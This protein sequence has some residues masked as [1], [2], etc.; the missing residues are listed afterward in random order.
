MFSSS[1]VDDRC[2]VQPEAGDLTN[3]PK[4]FRGECFCTRNCQ[5][6]PRNIFWAFV[7]LSLVRLSVCNLRVSFPCRLPLQDVS[8][9]SLL[10]AETVLEGDETKRHGEHRGHS[11]QK[12]TRM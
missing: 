8:D 3:P 1:L 10:S 4:K 2:V 11:S 6:S 5:L 9:E 12:V 7:F